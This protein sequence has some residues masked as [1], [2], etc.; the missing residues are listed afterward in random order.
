VLEWSWQ[1]QLSGAVRD[2]NS[3]LKWLGLPEPVSSAARAAADEFPVLVPHSFLFR[4]RPGDPAD[5]LLRQVLARDEERLAP[6]GFLV[7]PVGDD[8]AQRAPGMLQKYRGRV[9]LITTG[10]CAIHCRYCFRRHFPYAEAPHRPADWQPALDLIAADASISEVILSGGDPLVL[11]DDRLASLWRRLEAIPHLRRV[12]LHT[13]LPIVL[14]ARVTT[15]L[16]TL[17]TTSRL[18]P[19]VVV[20]ANHA[21]ELIDD[22]AEGLLRLT[23]AGGLVVF[24]QAVLLAGVNDSVAALEELSEALFRLKV[25]PY[26]L[27]QLDRVLGGAHFEVPV[28]R[29]LEL[30]ETLRARVPGYLLP[31]YVQEVP[32][33]PSKQPLF[34]FDEP[35]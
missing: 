1:R 2:S 12:R 27:H 3:L 19:V 31:R 10:A 32:G 15:E 16:L 5:P 7:D 29:G 33:E 9:L 34:E 8:M 6:E 26:Y 13:R 22:C 35:S 18:Q 23:S 17:L 28:S 24:N 14:P 4:M 21:Q 11:A 25:I 20:H 30:L